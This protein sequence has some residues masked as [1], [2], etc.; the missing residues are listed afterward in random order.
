[1][2]YS[3]S[4]ENLSAVIEDDTADFVST[5]GVLMDTWHH[6]FSYSELRAIHRLCRVVM[7]RSAALAAVI[8]ASIARKTRH[9]QPAMS[10]VSVAIDGSL[11]RC[12]P[13]F[14]R[15]LRTHL[16]A[17]LGKAVSGLIHLILADDGSGKGASILASQFHF[18]I[19]FNCLHLTFYLRL[20]TC[21]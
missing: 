21:V 7:D 17:I 8:I 3:F 20:A 2:H 18:F 4:S 13:F 14:Q 11:Y 6:E 19:G 12:A 5:A 10:G 1:M 9:L 15:Q 16:D